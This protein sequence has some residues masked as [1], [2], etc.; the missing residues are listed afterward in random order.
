MIIF[1]GPVPLEGCFAAW[2]AG[3]CVAVPPTGRGSRST[4]SRFNRP[5]LYEPVPGLVLGRG[6]G[7]KS[8]KE[9]SDYHAF[10]FLRPR[11]V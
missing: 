1:G 9:V 11:P 5:G 4:A 2:Q 6:P 7:T 8:F 10:I 3:I